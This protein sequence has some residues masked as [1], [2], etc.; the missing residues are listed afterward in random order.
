VTSLNYICSP[1][2]LVIDFEISGISD[3]SST[4]IAAIA[5]AIDSVLFES[6]DPSRTGKIYL[7]DLNRAIGDV[8]ERL[9]LF[10]SPHLQ[11]LS[12]E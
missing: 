5:D 1:T 4:T 6:A 3:V 12:L 9:V 11:I 2:E 8:S 10:W 7:S